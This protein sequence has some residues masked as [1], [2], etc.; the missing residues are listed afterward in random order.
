[1]E[2]AALE[3]R[4]AALQSRLGF[5]ASDDRAIPLQT[6]LHDLSEKLTRIEGS[7]DPPHMPSLHAAYQRHEKV[8]RPDVLETLS[9]HG[10]ASSQQ[11][12]KAIVLTSQESVDKLAAQ[13]QRLK[14]LD[15]AV[16]HAKFPTLSQ[17]VHLALN[18]VETQNLLVTRQVLAQHQAV[19]SLL[20]QYAAIVHGMSK[21]FQLYD[22]HVRH[23]EKK[24]GVQA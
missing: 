15:A 5:H 4:V 22:A 8:L 13:A 2:V 16:L 9:E 24:A 14:E 11:W 18:R 19:E 3:R 23:L 12:K 21:K 1:M 7:I 10:S 20:T 17:D 6:R